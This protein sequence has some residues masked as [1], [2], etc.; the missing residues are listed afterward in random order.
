MNYQVN[1]KGYYGKF[2]GAWIPEMMYANIEELKTK[3]LEI[4]D[5]EEFK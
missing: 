2:G 1:E 4:I 3:Y 5:S